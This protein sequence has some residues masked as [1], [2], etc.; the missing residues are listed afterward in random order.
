MNT[1]KIDKIESFI[2][3]KKNKSVSRAGTKI[4]LPKLDPINKTKSR[5]NSP[6]EP[7]YTKGNTLKKVSPKSSK[8]ALEFN[9]TF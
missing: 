4:I 5:K 3:K 2:R 1:S 8:T 9:K 7:R 6:K